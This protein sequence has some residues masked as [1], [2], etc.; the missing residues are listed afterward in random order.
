MGAPKKPTA[1]PASRPALSAGRRWRFYRL[2]LADQLPAIGSGR[3]WVYAAVGWK[4]VRVVSQC[5]YHRARVSRRA[6]DGLR[7]VEDREA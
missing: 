4:W 3:R 5:G 2:H 7:P 1:K 6:W